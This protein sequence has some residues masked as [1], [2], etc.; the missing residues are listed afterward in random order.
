VQLDGDRD[1]L[2]S[3]DLAVVDTVARSDNTNAYQIPRGH[4]FD[5][6]AEKAAVVGDLDLLCANL[7]TRS[8]LHANGCLVAASSTVP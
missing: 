6:D 8:P 2:R 7:P 3:H 4:A 5:D 1:F